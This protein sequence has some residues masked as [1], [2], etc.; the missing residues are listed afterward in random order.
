MGFRQ[1]CWGGGYLPGK[2]RYLS[3]RWNYNSLILYID[4]RSTSRQTLAFSIQATKPPF[5][6]L[7]LSFIPNGL[8]MGL[9]DANANAFTTRLPSP[10]QKMSLLHAVYG[11]GA[12]VTPLVGT[13]FAREG[14]RGRWQGFYLCSVVV[15]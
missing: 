9:Q 11:L 7:L 13:Q 6:I 5:P 8:G 2:F 1:G 10:S 14:M 3:S 12:F 4:I 15:G